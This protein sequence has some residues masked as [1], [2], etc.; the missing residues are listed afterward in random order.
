[1]NLRKKLWLENLAVLIVIAMLAGIAG[2]AVVGFI[3]GR[4]T[5]TMSTAR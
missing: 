5:S 1:M 3:S 4:T 2:G